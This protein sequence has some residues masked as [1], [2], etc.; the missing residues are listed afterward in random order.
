MTIFRTSASFGGM[1][2]DAS[3]IV[4]AFTSAVKPDLHS[5][6]AGASLEQTADTLVHESLLLAKK[7][8]TSFFTSAALVVVLS[9]LQNRNSSLMSYPFT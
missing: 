2:F 6:M 9:G 5:S 1:L 7:S 3:A 4:H 8:S